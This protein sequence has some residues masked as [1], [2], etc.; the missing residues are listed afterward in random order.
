MG[1]GEGVIDSEDVI[2]VPCA[3]RLL[4]DDASAFTDDLRKLLFVG[5]GN[6]GLTGGV[7]LRLFEIQDQTVNGALGLYLKHID[8]LSHIADLGLPHSVNDRSGGDLHL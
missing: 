3:E 7:A 2:G 5:N 4:V 1:S 8:R 6:D